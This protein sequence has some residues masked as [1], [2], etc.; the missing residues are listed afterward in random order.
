MFLE[1]PITKPI[2]DDSDDVVKYI[3]PHVIVPLSNV[4]ITEGE[5]LKLACKIDGYPKP[6]VLNAKSHFFH[7]DFF[8]FFLIIYIHSLHGI[9]IA[10]F[11]QHALDTRLTMT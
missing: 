4:K 6:K 11:Y 9:K 2:K 3:P 1:H 5:P 8:I 10:S 7:P